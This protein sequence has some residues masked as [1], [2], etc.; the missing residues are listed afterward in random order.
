MG[1][2][3]DLPLDGGTYYASKSFIDPTHLQNQQNQD[4]RIS[5]GWINEESSQYSYRGWAG[6]LS[7][8]R[9]I[10]YDSSLQILRT[11]PVSYLSFI[12]MIYYYS[13]FLLFGRLMK[14]RS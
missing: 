4:R 10:E 13:H 2:R 14:S 1:G 6:S 9:L 11:P 5:W 8:P 12:F 3:G 7:L